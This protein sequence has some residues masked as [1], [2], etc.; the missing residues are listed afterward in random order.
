[1]NNSTRFI[2]IIPWLCDSYYTSNAHSTTPLC[3]CVK[4]AIW[5][6]TGNKADNFI[7]QNAKHFQIS[8]EQT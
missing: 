5:L 8:G 3:Y 1:M 6:N 7:I 2:I 4:V